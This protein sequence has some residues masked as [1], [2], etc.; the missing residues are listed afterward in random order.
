MI[1]IFVTGL[2]LMKRA[3][4]ASWALACSSDSRMAGFATATAMT[5]SGDKQTLIGALPKYPLFHACCIILSKS[6]LRGKWSSHSLTIHR[7]DTSWSGK[8]P[9]TLFPTLLQLRPKRSARR[10]RG[11]SIHVH[12]AILQPSGCCRT[13]RST[14]PQNI[15]LSVDHRTAVTAG[16]EQESA[17]L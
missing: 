15:N 6:T 2:G 14:L 4:C 11:S 5:Q 1:T 7:H 3:R 10:F 13:Q 12:N 8:R 17:T 16:P 9:A